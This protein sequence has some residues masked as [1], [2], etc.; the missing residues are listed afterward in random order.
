M[1]DAVRNCHQLVGIELA[2]C[3][4]MAARYPA[5]F[6]GVASE[7]GQIKPG[8]RAD[9]VLFDSDFTVLQTWVAGQAML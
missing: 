9:M 8:Y 3:L 2:E 4:R 6:L 1:I 7:L 5:E